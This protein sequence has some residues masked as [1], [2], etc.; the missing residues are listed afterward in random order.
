[1]R[2]PALLS[3]AFFLVISGCAGTTTTKDKQP[4]YSA[5]QLQNMGENYLAA[6]DTA[7][8]LQY[9]TEA[10]QKNPNNPVIQYD[11]GLAYDQRELPNKAMEHFEKAL[12][13]KPDYPEALNAIGSVYAKRGQIELAQQAFKKAMDNP[14]YKTPEISAYNIGRLYEKKDDLEMALTYYQQAVKFNQ[15]FG[16]AW[17]HIGLILEQLH[18]ADEARHA[19]GN[20]VKGSPDLA[21]AQLRYGIM[22]YQAGDMEAAV[23]SLSR[24]GRL[25]PNTY[26]AD[27]AR[28]YL[29]KL[30][31]ATRTKTRSKSSSYPPPDE[32][33]VPS[34]GN[35]QRQQTNETLPSPP[36]F[37]PP[38]I[39]EDVNSQPA[40]VEQEIP[41]ETQT[42]PAKKAPVSAV[43]GAPAQGSIAEDS[44]SQSYK[45]IVQVGSFVDREKAEEFKKSLDGKGYKALVK[46]LKHKVLGKVFVIQLQ[47]VGSV[48]KATTLMTQLS[49]EVQ[50][51]P[52][53]IKV[54]A[55]QNP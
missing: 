25:V 19:Y 26:M 15:Q 12:K 24:V 49:S 54:P 27:E 45:Y 31:E 14:F 52:V 8:A 3:F 34:N 18:R 43:D 37:P 9:L 23:S 39:R 20:A 48:A 32:I 33:G 29:E 53:I 5:T 28:R 41:E 40:P 22:S 16:T 38:L 50:G 55:Q 7:S 46:P 30:S 4:V 10:E 1:M 17:L 21:E 47:P 13:I 36:Q 51:E 6:S 11:L 42:S 35:I 2:R 44:G